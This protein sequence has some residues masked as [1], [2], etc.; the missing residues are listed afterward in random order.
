MLT[1]AS[2]RAGK[3]IYKRLRL[4]VLESINFDYRITNSVVIAL[5]PTSTIFLMLWPMRRGTFTRTELSNIAS[6]APVKSSDIL[7]IAA[8]ET[9]RSPFFSILEFVV[10]L[11]ETIARIASV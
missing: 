4:F 5:S 2:N 9:S 10:D 1:H 8:F 11:F 7:Y 3:E 6:R